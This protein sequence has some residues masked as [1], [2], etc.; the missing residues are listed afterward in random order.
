[1]FKKMKK[2]AI[3]TQ[4]FNGS[5]G[6]CSKRWKSQH[7][8]LSY[9]MGQL[10]NV[11]KDEKV[12]ITRSIIQWVSISKCSKRWKS[13]HYTLNYSMG[14]LA[15]VQKDKKFSI[16]RSA[17][18]WVYSISNC[19]KWWKVSITRLAIQ[20]VFWK[21]F[22]KMKKSAL[23]AHTLQKKVSG[24]PVHRQDATNQTLPGRE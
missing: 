1:M 5:F 16:T 20:W 15:K 2:S 17:I 3:P 21:M 8:T 6:K 23:C 7:Y 14:L 12:S 11:Q 10:A 9:S 19:P 24:F 4:P 18:Q 13:Q 22:K